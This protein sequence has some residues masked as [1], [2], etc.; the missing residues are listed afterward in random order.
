[1]AVD[2]VEQ[3][4]NRP[5]DTRVQFRTDRSGLPFSYRPNQLITVGDAVDHLRSRLGDAW[6]ERRSI[7]PVFIGKQQSGRDLVLVRGVPDPVETAAELR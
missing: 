6:A 5:W 7:E 4:T 2:R 1:M 3:L